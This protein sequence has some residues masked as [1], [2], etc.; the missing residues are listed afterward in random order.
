MLTAGGSPFLLPN[1]PQAKFFSFILS[2]FELKKYKHRLVWL[3]WA[4]T[5]V[6]NSAVCVENGCDSVVNAIGTR[7]NGAVANAKRG[8]VQL[9]NRI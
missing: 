9:A 7:C 5:A 3:P 1:Y 6:L 2:G 4:A 8:L